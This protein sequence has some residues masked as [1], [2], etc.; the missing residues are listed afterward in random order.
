[1]SPPVSDALARIRSWGEARD[2][3]GWDPYD[4]LNSP[5]APVLTLGTPLGRRVLTQAV[6]LSPLNLR[7]AL[8]IRRAYNDKA[9]ALV[10]SG[11]AR[12]YASGDET[13]AEPARRWL[14]WLGEH[15]QR[16]EGGLAW[17][18][19]FPVQTRVFRYERGAPNAIA[20]SFVAQALLDAVELL[21][22]PRWGEQARAAVR[23][24][25]G[26]LR[27]GPHFAYLE[28]EDELVHNANL[29]VCAVL[30]RAARVM[31]DEQLLDAVRPALAVTLAVQRVD[32]SWPYADRPRHDWVDNFHTGYVLGALAECARSLPE[33]VEPL[34][35]GVQYW[36]RELFLPDGRPKYYATQPWPLDA[37]CYATGVDTWVALAAQHPQALERAERL[38]ALLVEDMLTPAGYVRFQR[39]RR[40]TNSVAL[41]RWSTAPA[42]KALAGLMHA[43]LG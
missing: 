23:F 32:G 7:P 41:V 13:A 40:Y 17:G 1:M 31:G 22:E 38:A 18:Y 42:F 37:H 33:A 25:L 24:L 12:L 27:A 36:E 9:I 26:P 3:R 20:T 15:A 4:G 2:W 14:A 43:R 11:Y 5:L 6:K 28:G 34:A 30:A 19:H 10:A 8:G 39:R 21:G 35:R 29:L 16:D